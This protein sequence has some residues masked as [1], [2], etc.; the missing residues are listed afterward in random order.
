MVQC[1]S[2][3]GKFE[4]FGVNLAWWCICAPTPLGIEKLGIE[5]GLVKPS[6]H[7]IPGHILDPGDCRFTD[8]VY[9][10]GCD[11][12]EADTGTLQTVVCGPIS[13]RE[14][15]TTVLAT[16]SSPPTLP[17][18]VEGMTDDIA[19]SVLPKM[20]AVFVGTGE[21]FEAVFVVHTCVMQPKG[22]KVKGSTCFSK[23]ESSSNNT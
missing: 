10:H 22:L 12:V 16:V 9:G 20:R 11:L 19:L 17:G 15:P 14:G 21:V 23:A 8:A 2:G 13:R 3:W 5:K 4:G 18:F 6:I 7:C 1:R